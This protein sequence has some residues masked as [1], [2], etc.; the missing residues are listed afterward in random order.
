MRSIILSLRSYHHGGLFTEEV[1]CIIASDLLWL[2]NLSNIAAF[3][4]DC[5]TMLAGED[6]LACRLRGLSS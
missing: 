6:L 2:L 4:H 1:S 5:F 3:A